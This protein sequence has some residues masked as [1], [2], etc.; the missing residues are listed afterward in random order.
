M[1]GHDS[2]SGQS[3]GRIDI[4]DHFTKKGL[5][6]I[7]GFLAMFLLDFKAIVLPYF[8]LT[9]DYAFPEIHI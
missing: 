5:L 2:Y 9:E 7:Y 3:P 4:F 8:L 1:Q 6:F